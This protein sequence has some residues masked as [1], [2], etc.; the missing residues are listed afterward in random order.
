MTQAQQERYKELTAKMMNNYYF[1]ED[2]TEQNYEEYLELRAIEQQEFRQAN[3]QSLKDFFDKHIK[4]KKW[5]DINDEDWGY[6]SDY[7]KEVYGY[8]PKSLISV[9]C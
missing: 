1:C 8:R 9:G 6:Y 7:H 4:G 2:F 5:E 3:E